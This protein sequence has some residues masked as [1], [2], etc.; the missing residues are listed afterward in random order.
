MSEAR[1]PGGVADLTLRHRA[2]QPRISN[3]T[4]ISGAAID[5]FASGPLP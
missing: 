1:V 5:L 2:P 4:S 3:F